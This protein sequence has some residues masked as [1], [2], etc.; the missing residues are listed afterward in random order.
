MI[1]LTFLGLC[2][3]GLILLLYSYFEPDQAPGY[4]TRCFAINI[5]TTDCDNRYDEN[6]LKD[7]IEKITIL[8]NEWNYK[9]IFIET[10]III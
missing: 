9:L 6:I 2:I 7:E 1:I 4:Y 10:K 5:K 8:E 3:L